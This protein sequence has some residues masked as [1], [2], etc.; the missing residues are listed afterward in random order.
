MGHHQE[1]SQ[2]RNVEGKGHRFFLFDK[3]PATKRI[4]EG[5]NGLQGQFN[6]RGKRHWWEGRKKRAQVIGLE[7][8]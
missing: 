8:P 4:R 1:V 7:E 3:E 5:K 6:G 2:R